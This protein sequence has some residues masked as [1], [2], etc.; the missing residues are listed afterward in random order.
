MYI[1]VKEVNVNHWGVGV[2]ETNKG[3]T[4]TLEVIALN[5]Q[6]YIYSTQPTW[7]SPSQLVNLTGLSAYMR[8]PNMVS[9]LG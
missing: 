4:T 1:Y 2:R 6:C 7:L 5:Q 8:A 3:R 9:N